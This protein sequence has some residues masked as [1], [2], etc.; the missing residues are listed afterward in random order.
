MEKKMSILGIGHI[1]S[2]LTIFYGAIVSFITTYYYPFFQVQIIPYYIMSSLGIVLIVIGLPFLIIS[3]IAIMQA[4]N[5]DKLVIHGIYRCCRNP[6]YAAWT[7][8]IVPGITL[9]TNSWIILSIPIFM[10]IIL[11]FLV[12]KEEEYLYETF[13][14]EYLDYKKKVPFIIPYGLMKKNV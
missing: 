7:V 10:Y 1:F 11:R 5:R 13:G 12:K 9:L 6:L 4:Y 14:T 3:V 2:L 8:F